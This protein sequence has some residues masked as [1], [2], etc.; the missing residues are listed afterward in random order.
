MNRIPVDDSIA[1][2]ISRL[3]DDAQTER[4][5]PSHSDITFELEN[6]GLIQFDPN[7]KGNP[8]VGKAKRIRNV[9]FAALETNIDQ[10]ERFAFSFLS[11][12]KA[13]GGFR[14]SSPNYVRSDA[15]NNLRALLKSHGINLTEDGDIQTEILEN[16]SGSELTSALKNYMLRAKK[17]TEDAA[18]LVGTSKDLLEAVAAHVIVELWGSYSTTDNFPTLIGLSFVALEM[19]T[20]ADKKVQGEHPRKDVERSLYNLACSVNRLRNKQGTGHG[21]PWLPDVS[22]IEAKNAVE[23]MGIIAELM[24]NRLEEKKK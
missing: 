4:R 17:G 16:L 15:L 20:D 13:C 24:L 9:L 22:P 6:A 19:A 21:R 5:D 14:D 1:H 3:V 18:L 7:K 10:V 8:P 11:T 23:T 2:A 12:I